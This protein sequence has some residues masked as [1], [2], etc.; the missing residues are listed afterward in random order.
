MRG[1][2]SPIGIGKNRARHRGNRRRSAPPARAN[3]ATQAGDGHPL[4]LYEALLLGHGEAEIV[5]SV[6]ALMRA[7][8][9]RLAHK[10]ARPDG[11]K[12]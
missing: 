5:A 2:V 4:G 8:A 11:R 1:V 9:D 10:R 3:A 12:R 7:V 6:E